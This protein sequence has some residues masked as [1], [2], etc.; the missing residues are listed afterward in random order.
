MQIFVTGTGTNIGKTLVSSWLCL[1]SRYK[2]FKPIQT[3]NIEGTDSDFVSKIANV[4]II[5]E[6]YS[7]KAPLSPHLASQLEGEII[8]FNQISLPSNDNNIIIE[9]AGGIFVPINNQ[10]LMI[11]L[12]KK[13]N[14]P[15]IIAASSLLGTINHSLMTISILKQY[16]I[17]IL[18]VICSGPLNQDNY[19]AIEH[20]GKVKILATIPHLDAINTQ[21]LLNIPLTKN[22]KI[23]L[24]V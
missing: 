8:D 10:F 20:F 24:G 23:M 6:I 7:Y 15:V 19:D 5:P 1:H 16:D 21:N 11:D 18:G 13:L 3:G 2:Y 14:L 9:G 17:K 4:E 22:L 12:I